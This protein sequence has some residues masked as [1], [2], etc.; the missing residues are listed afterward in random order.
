MVKNPPA[1]AGDA[2]SFPG[3]GRNP[4]EKEMASS[5]EGNTEGNTP[6]FWPGKSHGQRSLAGDSPWGHKE[7][8]MAEH[9]CT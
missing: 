5:I 6:V 9:S 1:R 7:L 2:G 4:L 8:D 3:L